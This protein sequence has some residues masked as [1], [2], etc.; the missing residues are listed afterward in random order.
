MQ[1]VCVLRRRDLAGWEPTSAGVTWP[2]SSTAGDIAQRGGI[3]SGSTAI[4]V[5]GFRLAAGGG[6]VSKGGSVAV[7]C[8]VCPYYAS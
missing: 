1:W 3:T 6:V 8:A 7:L 5:W 4:A 2:I